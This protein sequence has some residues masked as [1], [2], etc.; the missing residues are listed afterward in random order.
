MVIPMCTLAPAIVCIML[1]MFMYHFCI[2]NSGPSNT[3]FV[4]N[5]SPTTTKSSL[6]K[7]FNGCVNATVM[8]DPETGHNKG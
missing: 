8:T 5:L 3:L 2:G 6:V 1:T 7:V 4:K